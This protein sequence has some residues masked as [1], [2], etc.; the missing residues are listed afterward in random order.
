M[1]PSGRCE[2]RVKLLDQPRLAQAWLAHDQSKLTIAHPGALPAPREQ[3]Q[4]LL[5]TNERRQRPR[6]APPTAAAGAN[7]AE[8]LDRLDH[9]SELAR[10]LLLGD[11]ETGDLPL[12]VQ[13][14]EHRARVGGGLRA[15]GDIRRVAE[16]L[17]CR[18]H[19]NR[20]AFDPDA[21]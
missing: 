11:E 1:T 21:R 10:A 6:A 2:P 5:A 17:A 12:D 18:L 14:N 19:Y 13:R 15:S 4:F 9:A 20:P 16:H 7:D 8:E 3:A